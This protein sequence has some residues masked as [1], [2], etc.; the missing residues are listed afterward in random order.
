MNRT[1]TSPRSP[2][3]AL[4]LLLSGAALLPA[5][6]LPRPAAAQPMLDPSQMSGIPRPDPQVPAGTITVRLI[7][8]ALTNRLTD[9]EVEL[10]DLA[11]KAGEAPRRAKTDAEGRATFSELPRATYEARAVAD[12][13]ALASQPIALPES[14]GVRVMLVFQKSIADQQ[15]ELG[16]PDG[17]ARVDQGLPAGTLVVKVVDEAGKPLADLA[18]ALHHGDRAT[19]KVDQLPEQK[20]DAQGVAR[21]DRLKAGSGDGYMVGVTRGGSVVRSKPFRL[22]SSHGSTLA[23]TAHQVVRDASQV[24]L[25]NGSHIILDVADD[26]VQVVENLLVKNPLE[27]TIDPGPAGL[28]IPLAERALSAQLLNAG[29]EQNP[30]LSIDVS[31]ADKPPAVLWRGPIPPG[32]HPVRAGFLLKHSGDLQFRQELA[33]GGESLLVAVAKLPT[34]SVRGEGLDIQDRKI[35]GKDWIFVRA[36]EG[37]PQKAGTVLEFRASGFPYDAPLY[38]LAAGAVALAIAVAFGVLAWRG[39]RGPAGGSG[40]ER[41]EALH[42]RREALL[43]ELQRLDAAGQGRVGRGR[44]ALLAELEQVYQ[45]LDQLHA[46]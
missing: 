9:V 46:A 12:G 40:R 27:Q 43:A 4:V 30:R 25:G 2:R 29:E 15:K 18:V 23:L 21:W 45:E 13:E 22:E 34:V 24:V 8:G 1:P 11:A 36:Q 39:P 5:P 20:T 38:R 28:R 44:E 14:P 41:R 7:R 32:N 17:A 10:V 26:A 33:L 19:E 37:K 16:T 31:Q 42:L 35:E 6:L 3:T